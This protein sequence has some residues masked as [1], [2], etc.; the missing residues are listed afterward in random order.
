MSNRS[1]HFV[2]RLQALPS[3][4]AGV[5]GSRRLL[6]LAAV[7]ALLAL[8]LLPT[9]AQAQT[10]TPWVSNTGQS[11]SSSSFL[12]GNS[13]KAVSQGFT[14]GTASGGYGL[15]SVGVY[16]VN[17]DLETGETFTVHIYTATATGAR[18]TLVYTLT[19]PA[20]YTDNAV[21]VFTAPPN[22]RLAASTDYLVVFE[23]T[24][25]TGDDFSLGLTDSNGEDSGKATGWSIENARRL[26]NN[27]AS[28]GTAL[29]I[30]VVPPTYAPDDVAVV[31]HNWPLI[32]TGV[33][34][35]Q[36]FRLIFLTSTTRDASSTDIG[37]YNTFI[38]DRAAAGHEAIRE[39]Q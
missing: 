39:Y 26:N 28:T 9:V 23:G 21:N 6:A 10:E 25:N 29:L 18:D 38:Q 24:G 17:E 34:P 3:A 5:S 31:P 4:L 14:T 11:R 36:Q 15:G 19:S 30:S 8:T 2:H 22:A 16:V 27:L 13:D 32:P 20:S 1:S 35:G 7:L 33:G 37:D 12:T